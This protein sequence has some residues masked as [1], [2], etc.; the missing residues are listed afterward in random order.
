MRQHT[1]TAGAEEL[2]SL[3]V[4]GLHSLEEEDR[5]SVAVVGRSLAEEVVRHSWVVV[6]GSRHAAV[7]R[8]IRL[9]E[10]MTLCRDLGT[11]EAL[12]FAFKR[13]KVVNCMP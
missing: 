10:R 8:D 5:S 1:D 6:E 2:H 9:P 13:S 4:V 3:A 12:V 7:L 11:L